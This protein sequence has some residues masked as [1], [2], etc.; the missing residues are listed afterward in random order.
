LEAAGRAR[1]PFTTGILIGIGETYEE[2]IDALLAIRAAHATF[3]HVQEVIVQNFRAKHHT[4]M[5]DHPEPSLEDMRLTIA[6][7]RLILPSDIS[8]QVPPNL[9][10]VEYGS[11]LECGINDWGGISPVTPDHV[12]PERPWPN[13]EE[14]RGVTEGHGFLL[15]E[16][17]AAYPRFVATPAV[18]D[19]W[20]DPQLHGRVLD[21]TDARGYR[22]PNEEWYSGADVAPPDSA[23][24]VL[25]AARAGAWSPVASSARA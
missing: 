20:I 25:D 8:V 6:L 2:R 22:R 19:E 9:T 3:G 14:L 18:L 17:L 4:L 23:A 1:V 7:A 5:A 15:T 16:R 21:A 13:L 10:P 11:F 12:N 24:I